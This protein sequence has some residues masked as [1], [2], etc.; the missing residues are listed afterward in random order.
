MRGQTRSST[1]TRPSDLSSTQRTRSSPSV[2][3]LSEVWVPISLFNP[4]CAGVISAHIMQ[5]SAGALVVFVETFMVLRR[6]LWDCL[7]PEGRMRCWDQMWLRAQHENETGFMSRSKYIYIKKNKNAAQKWSAGF[8]LAHNAGLAIT[9]PWGR[10][11]QDCCCWRSSCVCQIQTV[12][13]Y[14]VSGRNV[15]EAIQKRFSYKYLLRWN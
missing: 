2:S 13:K 9:F 10:Y 6:E 14:Y 3:V 11:D 4:H 5:S 1:K 15:A 8:R 12:W 7:C